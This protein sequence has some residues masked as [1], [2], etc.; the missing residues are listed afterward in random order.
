MCLSKEMNRRLEQLDRV[1]RW[2]LS[3]NLWQL[4][5]IVLLIALAINIPITVAE[6]QM[7]IDFA[8]IMVPGLW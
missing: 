1:D 2:L 3:L 5:R 7:S 4:Q 8:T 6:S